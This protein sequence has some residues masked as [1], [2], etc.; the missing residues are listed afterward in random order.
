MASIHTHNY[1]NFTVA[2][3]TIILVAA[4]LSVHRTTKTIIWFSS[5][6][7]QM[8]PQLLYNDNLKEITLSS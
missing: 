8:P 7:S 4:L 2:S 1:G 3:F 5:P 6:T